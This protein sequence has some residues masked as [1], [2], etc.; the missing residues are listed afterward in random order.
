M[1]D[2]VRK[3]FNLQLVEVSILSEGAM[4][5]SIAYREAFHL[6]GAQI[7][8]VE[9]L[10][11]DTAIL[12]IHLKSLVPIHSYCHREVQVTNTAIREFSGNK[13]AVCSKLFDEPCLNADNFTA[14]ESEPYR[15]DGC[16]DPRDSS[17]PCQL[18]DCLLVVWHA[19][20]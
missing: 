10:A 5:L 14:L 18:S 2:G 19:H 20:L 7:P 17:V 15:Q 3:A 13:P 8:W 4:V 9:G 6:T 1:Q 16:H 12:T 11:N